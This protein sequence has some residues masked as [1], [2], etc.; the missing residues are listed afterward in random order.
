[1]ETRLYNLEQ[2]ADTIKLNLLNLTQQV[3][4]MNQTINN[5]QTTINNDILDL[6]KPISWFTY[7]QVR[8]TDSSGNTAYGSFIGAWYRPI[9]FLNVN[10][11]AGVDLKILMLVLRAINISPLANGVPYNSDP[12]PLP[13][14]F[15]NNNNFKV[16]WCSSGPNHDMNTRQAAYL[17]YNV[18]INSWAL[19][20]V[21][22]QGTSVQNDSAWFLMGY[23]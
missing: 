21:L 17:L 10:S 5:I 6:Y 4:G 8:F 20:V 11:N 22:H 1:V 23:I 13:I 14:S 3:N 16:F 19:N 9:K 2:F 18:T 15:V 7:T 12:L